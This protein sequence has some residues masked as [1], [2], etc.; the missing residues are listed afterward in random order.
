M[1]PWAGVIA[2]AAV[3]LELKRTL[4]LLEDSPCPCWDSPCHEPCS[5]TPSSE[6]TS[7]PASLRSHPRSCRDLQASLARWASAEAQWALAEAPASVEELWGGT[8]GGECGSTTPSCL[9]STCSQGRL[10]S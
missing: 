9:P 6:Q 1:A 3:E 5:T 8:H 7:P 2:L 4:Q 10:R